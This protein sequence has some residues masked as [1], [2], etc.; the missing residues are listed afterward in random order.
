MGTPWRTR[1]STTI[2][3]PDSRRRP[4]DSVNAY[5]L[6]FRCNRL[7]LGGGRVAWRGVLSTDRDPFGERG[8]NAMAPARRLHRHATWMAVEAP[9]GDA[10]E[11][12]GWPAPGRRHTPPANHLARRTPQ[13]GPV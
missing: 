1:Y 12:Y 7:P 10:R 11:P 5:P 2:C 9:D 4:S 8:R 6:R 13:P 3:A